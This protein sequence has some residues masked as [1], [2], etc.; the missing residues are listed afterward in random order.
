MTELLLL[1]MLWIWSSTDRN[2]LQNTL[3]GRFLKHIITVNFNSYN[4][5][6]KTQFTY[7]W[8]KSSAWKRGRSLK[9]KDKSG[10]RM[11][12]VCAINLGTA[13]KPIMWLQNIVCRQLTCTEVGLGSCQTRTKTYNTCRRNWRREMMNGERE[14]IK[15]S[16]GWREVGES[17]SERWKQTQSDSIS[18]HYILAIWKFLH[19]FLGK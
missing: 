9:E 18:P 6:L 13:G 10:Q 19:W 3:Q 11:E 16:R 5:Y 17:L 8:A 7:Y 12:G 2:T 1:I 14:I 4:M 15:E